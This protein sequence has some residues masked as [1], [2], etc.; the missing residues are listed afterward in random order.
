MPRTPE[1]VHVRH[2]SDQYGPKEP[3]SPDSQNNPDSLVDSPLSLSSRSASPESDDSWSEAHSR[4]RRR[5]LARSNRPSSQEHLP[6]PVHA[7]LA[8]KGTPCP[9]CEKV[10][11][12]VSALAKHLRGS[13]HPNSELL[14]TAPPNMRPCRT[15]SKLY[16][17]GIGISNHETKCKQTARPVRLA[18]AANR[19]GAQPEAPALPTTETHQVPPG[20]APHRAQPRPVHSIPDQLVDPVR[21]ITLRVL[22][23]ILAEAEDSPQGPTA[24][25]VRALYAIPIALQNL[26]GKSCQRKTLR[27]LRQTLDAQDPTASL[28][29]GTVTETAP[30]ASTRQGPSLKKLRELV[31]KNCLSKAVAHISSSTTSKGVAAASPET[32]AALRQLFPP[33]REVDC[34]PTGLPAGSAPLQLQAEDID[35]GIN[36]LP[37]MSAAGWSGW[38]YDLI[39]AI[40]SGEDGTGLR[41]SIC[42]LANLMLAGRAGPSSIWNHD[43]VVPILKPNGGIR[44]IV[45]G[46]AWP[47]IVGRFAAAALSPQVG[48]SLLP[49]N[50]AIGAKGGAEVIAHACHFMEAAVQSPTPT[51]SLAMLNIDIKNAYGTIGRRFVFQGL[52]QLA[53]GLLHWFRWAYGPESSIHFGD[54]ELLN[55]AGVKQGDPLGCLLFCVA[56]HDVLETVHREFPRHQLLGLMDDAT[57][58]GPTDEIGTIQNRLHV[59]FRPLGLQLNLDKT[60]AWVPGDIPLPSTVNS[61]AEGFRVLGGFIGT[62]DYQLAAIR[63]EVDSMTTIVDIIQGLPPSLGLPILRACVNSRPV[64]LARTNAPWLT[65]DSLRD[66]DNLVDG[67]LLRLTSCSRRQLPRQAQLIRSLPQSAGGLGIPRLHDIRQSAWTASW[68]QAIACVNVYLPRLKNMSFSVPHLTAFNEANSVAQQIFP[69]GYRSDSTTAM[70]PVDWQDEVVTEPEPDAAPPAHPALVTTQKALCTAVHTASRAELMDSLQGDELGQ[71]WFLS[72][73]YKGSAGWTGPGLPVAYE[74]P[75]D[76]YTRALSL[77][78]LLPA[79]WLPADQHIVCRFCTVNKCPDARFHGLNCSACSGIRTTRHNAVRDAVADGLARI[80]SRA[81]V[82]VEPATGTDLRRPDILLTVDQKVWLI[83]ISVVNPAS[84]K[85]VSNGSATVAQAASTAM[86]TKKRADYA[87]TL[88]VLNLGPSALVPFVVEATG[89][90]G[91][92]ALEFL[93]AL[94]T[95]PGRNAHCNVSN[96]TRFMMG[97]ITAAIIRGNSLALAATAEH[98]QTVVNA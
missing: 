88:P 93:D 74:V 76:A 21:Q 56:V 57:I 70:Q 10:F 78:L 1:P 22:A 96:T 38:S 15:C 26:S 52:E 40:S 69:S 64:H 72:S 54:L 12:S 5:E 13:L 27:K 62:R 94:L 17:C 73:S 2:L 20:A 36:S 35:N 66:F 60:V 7:L 80:F 98:L 81:A 3:L 55:G 77:R 50:W 92:D 47:R 33:R 39:K 28:L 4:K 24:D 45:I 53:P 32:H 23:T 91:K 61:T 18:M 65:S 11:P 87:P 25:S 14:T 84:S 30:R 29:S 9:L 79:P 82:V 97:R 42:R 83:D 44:P 19:T 90:L 6:N 59:L 71:A 67:A 41:H 68:T 43:R 89:R 48:P 34:I 51:A 95:A 86:E 8:G 16:T 85:H 58:I 37:T 31:R 49:L 63:E 46:E 75:E